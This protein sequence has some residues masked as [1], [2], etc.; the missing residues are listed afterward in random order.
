[1]NA[2]GQ[3]KVEQFVKALPGTL[4]VSEN[5]RIVLLELASHALDQGKL[6]EP[7][8]LHQVFQLFQE[9]KTKTAEGEEVDFMLFDRFWRNLFASRTRV[10]AYHFEV[11][12]CER[13]VEDE[14]GRKR[15]QPTYT[16][17]RNE[18]NLIR[19]QQ[20]MQRYEKE[21]D[22]PT[23]KQ[24]SEPQPKELTHAAN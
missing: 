3:Q 15:G 1:M 23:P 21:A 16:F 24:E 20:Y 8:D 22:Q 13:E 9:T 4:G 18:D 5:N 2:T 11:R 7:L 19:I 17:Q 6:Q 10:D 14:Q 12:A